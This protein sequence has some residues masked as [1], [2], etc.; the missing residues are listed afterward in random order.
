MRS[1]INFQSPIRQWIAAPLVLVVAALS[2]PVVSNAAAQ[3]AVPSHKHHDDSKPV[4]APAPGLPL[5]PRLQNLGVHA[6]P[7]G[8]KVARA[9]LFMNQGLTSLTALTT[10]KRAARSRKRRGSIRRS[11]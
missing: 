10:R 3:T 2:S 6:F 7:V 4:P 11:P 9:Q 8:T 1:F 5:A